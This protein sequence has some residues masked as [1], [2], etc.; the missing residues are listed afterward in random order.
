MAWNRQVGRWLG[1]HPEIHTLIVS[2]IAGGP[3]YAQGGRG[4]GL[5][6]RLA[7]AAAVDHADH[8]HPRHAEGARLSTDDC[9]RARAGRPR[10]RR[11]RLP[12][13]TA[14]RSLPPDP[15]VTAAHRLTGRRVQVVDMTR[16]ICDRRWCYPVIGG[17][18]VYKDDNH[19]TEVFART[20]G[21]YL[22][23]ALGA[24]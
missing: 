10:V 23:Q 5:R 21:P 16:F 14:A 1:A 9:V 18:L 12:R 13:W 7:C 11:P 24:S 17:A 22:N 15:Q 3:T 19:L 6:G 4:G 8:R 20:L 2:A